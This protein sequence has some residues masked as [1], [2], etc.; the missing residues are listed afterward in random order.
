MI[1]QTL[2]RPGI[3]AGLSLLLATTASV[4]SANEPK[5]RIVLQEL[6]SGAIVEANRQIER[7]RT[8]DDA[9]PMLNAV[10]AYNPDAA[11][12]AIGLTELPL[13]G[14]TVLTYHGTL[15]VP[16]GA[17]RLGTVTARCRDRLTYGPAPKGSETRP[18]DVV[19]ELVGA[20]EVEGA[21]LP[22]ESSQRLTADRLRWVLRPA[23]PV[24]APPRSGATP[25]VRPGHDLL[26]VAFHASGDEVRILGPL[27]SGRAREIEASGLDR[28]DGWRLSL[29][30]PDAHVEVDER[31]TPTGPGDDPRG[32]TRGPASPTRRGARGS[33]RRRRCL[34]PGS[35]RGAA[36]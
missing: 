25:A 7:I 15:P 4:A 12:V 24:S 1:I 19:V 36:R 6:P 20:V 9:G 3:C 30:G 18:D 28:P 2:A 26:A 8:L 29:L 21:A 17:E 23:D 14:R 35:P 16:G 32:A 10:I 34:R 31:A 11:S 5:D 22:G 33:L 13:E 27:V